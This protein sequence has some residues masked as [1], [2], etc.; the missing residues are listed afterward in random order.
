MEMGKAALAIA[1]LEPL[2]LRWSDD[3]LGICNLG[4]AYGLAG[5]GARAR[6]LLQRALKLEPQSAT[7]LHALGVLEFQDGALQSAVEYFERA[8][9][10]QPDFP[11]CQRDLQIVRRKLAEQGNP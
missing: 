6:E 4:V 11:R 10:S 1:V 7:A 8:L 2:V 9:Q 5:D 3:F